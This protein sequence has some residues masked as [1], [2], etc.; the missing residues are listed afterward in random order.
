MLF[1]HIQIGELAAQL[2]AQVEGDPSQE[3]R[4]VAGL[5]AAGPADLSF[6]ANSKYTSLLAQTRA[7]AV[8]VDEKVPRPDSGVTLLRLPKPYLAF[9]KADSLLAEPPSYAAGVIYPGAHIHPSARRSPNGRRS[10]NRL[11]S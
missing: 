8:L 7:A 11:G 4:G 3:I 5:E 9:A 2:G 10:W 1:K 6:L